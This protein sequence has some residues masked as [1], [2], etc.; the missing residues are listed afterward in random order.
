MH[1]QKR[2]VW[3][4]LQLVLH[5]ALGNRNRAGYVYARAEA[6]RS[7]QKLL[8]IYAT[9]TELLSNTLRARA[10]QRNGGARQQL[11]TQSSNLATASSLLRE[12]AQRLAPEVTDALRAAVR[13]A[14]LERGL[15]DEPAELD[16][17]VE[18]VCRAITECGGREVA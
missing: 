4:L 15:G 18:A 12:A 13:T 5:D 10:Q 11:V 17:D 3:D 14:L 6:R 9:K 16:Q 2:G 7:F 8:G 1:R